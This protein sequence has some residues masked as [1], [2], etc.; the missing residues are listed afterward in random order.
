MSLIIHP[1][2][3][4]VAVAVRAATGVHVAV[5]VD[6]GGVVA[7]LLLRL[8]RL[9]DALAQRVVVRRARSEEEAKVAKSEH[10]K[11]RFEWRCLCDYDF[12][13]FQSKEQV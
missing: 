7:L 13:Q 11:F 5:A 1:G 6:G 8:R 12:I 9:C 2:A 3:V 10:L 4:F